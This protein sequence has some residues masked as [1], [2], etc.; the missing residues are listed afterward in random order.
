MS[1]KNKKLPQ[2]E[3]VFLGHWTRGSCVPCQLAEWPVNTI[4]VC[5]QLADECQ[6]PP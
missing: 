6:P 3:R 1:L 4:G 5:V 2:K